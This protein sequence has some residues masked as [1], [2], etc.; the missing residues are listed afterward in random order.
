MGDG[1][2]KAPA[3][4]TRRLRKEDGEPVLQESSSDAGGLS[5]SSGGGG[6]S[7][8]NGDGESKGAP[9]Q[10]QGKATKKSGKPPPVKPPTGGDKGNEAV[11]STTAP[12]PVET[13]TLSKQRRASGK[14]RAVEP[15]TQSRG[16]ALLSSTGDGTARMSG[17][18]TGTP[19]SRPKLKKN[20]SVDSLP[21]RAAGAAGAPA[22]G[23]PHVKRAK[24]LE[25]ADA[26][27]ASSLAARKAS[28]AGMSAARGARPP[29]LLSANPRVVLTDVAPKGRLDKRRMELS[30]RESKE[31]KKCKIRGPKG[32]LGTT[33]KAGYERVPHYAGIFRKVSNGKYFRFENDRPYDG[34]EY[35]R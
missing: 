24:S 3:R 1:Q 19:A 25:T 10:P 4:A 16:H 14:G 23:N 26:L 12:R 7:G 6:N 8:V 34:T 29:S 22:F 21:G 9:R 30:G 27:R 31:S 2:E 13:A 32:A 28:G 20:S 11:Q 35:A 5:D 17:S 15:P 33:S 18:L